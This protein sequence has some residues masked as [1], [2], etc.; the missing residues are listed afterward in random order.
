MLV[1]VLVLVFVVPLLALGHGGQP[2]ELGSALFFFS[3][4]KIMAGGDLI[5]TSAYF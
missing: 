2:R 3:A 1:L 5:L 4:A